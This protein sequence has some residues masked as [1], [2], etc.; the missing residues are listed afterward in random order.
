MDKRI[1][2]LCDERNSGGEFFVY[3]KPGWRLDDAHCFGEGSLREIRSTMARV[4][5]CTCGECLPAT[6]PA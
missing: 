6:R 1:D 3:L 5:R 2:E 4:Q